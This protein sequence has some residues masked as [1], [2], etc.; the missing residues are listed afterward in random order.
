MQARLNRHHVPHQD[1]QESSTPTP[2]SH[3]S[4]LCSRSFR[5]EDWYLPSLY[6]LNACVLQA[7]DQDTK[8]C[9]NKK[10]PHA[11]EDVKQRDPVPIP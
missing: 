8:E 2:R 11:H 3:L 4:F 9:W 10:V 5:M 1:F 6:P 7:K